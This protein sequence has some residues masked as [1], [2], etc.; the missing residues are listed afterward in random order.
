MQRP[1]A[2]T[3]AALVISLSPWNSV[4]AET[5]PENAIKYRMAV[6][7]AMAG[8]ASAFSMIAFGRVD[9]P[10]YQQ[11]HADALA[12][13]GAQLKALFPEG[14]GDGDTD[15][16]PAIWQEPDKFAEA[17]AQ[18]EEAMMNL[19][20]VAATG[21]RKAISDAFKATGDACKGC[22]EDY[23]AEHDHDH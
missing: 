23:R 8:H 14:S 15:A 16:L 5:T 6:M 20:E 21:N 4:G 13:A 9:L 22:H 18:A 12:A 3:V 10:E 2:G 7:Q 19:R 17:V 1:C 11:S